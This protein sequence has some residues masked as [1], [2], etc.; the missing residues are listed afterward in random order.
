MGCVCR[1][2]AVANRQADPRFSKKTAQQ[3]IK[4][5]FSG[6]GGE[7]ETRSQFLS[8]FPSKITK[9]CDFRSLRFELGPG[10]ADGIGAEL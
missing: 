10:F 8:K 7:Y 2:A 9:R 3:K 4:K 6:T 5:V 1:S